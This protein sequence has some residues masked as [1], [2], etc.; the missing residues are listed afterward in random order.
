MIRKTALVS[1]AVIALSMP[2][3]MQQEGLR[4]SRYYDAVGIAT[5]CYGETQEHLGK[6]SYSIKECNDLLKMKLGYFSYNLDVLVQPPMHPKLHAALTS[7]AYNVGLGAVK[8]S[9]LLRKLNAGDFIGACNQ[10]PRWNRAGNKVLAGLVKRREI[11]QNLCLSGAK[12]ML[13]VR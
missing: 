8:K 1:S 3:V 10:L 2:L 7:W 11:E 9:T 5:W 6:T 4:L 12:E 13:N